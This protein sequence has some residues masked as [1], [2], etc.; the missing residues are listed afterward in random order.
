MSIFRMKN[1]L[2]KDNMKPW[3]IAGLGEIGIVIFFSSALFSSKNFPLNI[4]IFQSHFE[5]DI[6]LFPGIRSPEFSA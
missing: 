1:L 6:C 3:A 4:F 2:V 5:M